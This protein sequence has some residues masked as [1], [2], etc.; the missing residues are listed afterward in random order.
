[1]RIMLYTGKGGVGKTSVAAAT[2]LRSAELGYRTIVLSTDAA[3]SLAD[4]FDRQL[5]PDPVEI[6]PNLWA[7]ELDV[8]HQMDLYWGV[9]Q[10]WMQAV[11][12][13]Q[14]TDQIV[15]DEV[16][17]LP[18]MEELAS[19]LQIV[20]LHDTKAYD[21][22]IV[23]CAPTGETLRLLTFPEV[24]RWWLE[25]IFPMQRRAAKVIRPML[26]SVIDM[27]LPGDD[28][29][30]SIQKLF[31]DLERMRVLLSDP[32]V[33][34]IRLVLNP[35]KMVI[36]EAQR[37]FAYLNLFGY[38]TDAVVV[39]RVMADEV[40]FTAI[41]DEAGEGALDDDCEDRVRKALRHWYSWGQMQRPYL[42]LIDDS[43][44]PVPILHCPFFDTEV[45]G[46]TM[47]RRMAEA[48]YGLTDPVKVLF[49]GR[50]QTLEQI[51]GTY[52][53][54]LPLPLVAK[55]QI[56]LTRTGDELVVR[57]GN[58]RRNLILPRSLIGLQ[59]KDA[60]LEEGVLRI[61]FVG[62]G[63]QKSK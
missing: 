61:T 23:D 15:A 19:L 27:P 2:A 38:S 33:A 29:F 54:S 4:S 21:C 7:Q 11:A 24:T 1:M 28:V 10:K 26:R 17:V 57:I 8:L 37:T 62:Q 16:T 53:L 12:L 5:S 30:A 22:I 36:K 48:T 6:A 14:G 31:G 46:P 25:R 3:H 18:G 56:D 52:V 44:A 13:W 20:Y 59:T 45:V 60:K 49:R 51:D 32:E 63:Q 47:L 9:I 39:N 42:Q 34:T 58:H 43:F 55:G 50:S 41:P 35:E 40:D